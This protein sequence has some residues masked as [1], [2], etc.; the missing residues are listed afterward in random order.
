LTSAN[1]FSKIKR[2]LT[3]KG[4]LP[5]AKKNTLL[6][7][8]HSWL[9]TEEKSENTIKT[10]L[11]VITKFMEWLESENKSHLTNETVQSY[12]DFLES[13]NLSAST[14]DKVFAAIRVF[15]QFSKSLEIVENIKRKEKNK[16]IYQTVPESLSDEEVK[17]LLTVVKKDGDIRNI[18]I[19]YTLLYTG[20]RI[21]ELCALNHADIRFHDLKGTLH[22]KELNGSRHIPLSKESITHL[23]KYMESKKDNREEAIFISSFNK[24]MTTRAVQYMLKKYNVNPH[25]LRHTFC[26]ELINKGMDI[27]IVAQLA[28]HDDINI[29]KRYTKLIKNGENA[30]GI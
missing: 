21:S 11:S 4:T 15:A 13:E 16:H 9:L 1:G 14:I 27:S 10:Y 18:A 28:G 2:N 25:K 26:Q 20:I 29:T 8:F 7:E 30:T 5:L 22:V 12:M 6:G 19:V 24:R 3:I 23:R 17:Q